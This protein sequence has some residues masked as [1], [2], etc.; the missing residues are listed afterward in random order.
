[1]REH[2]IGCMTRAALAKGYRLFYIGEL[3]YQIPELLAAPWV[4]GASNDS[5]LVAALAESIGIAQSDIHTLPGGNYGRVSYT[6]SY[7]PEQ[8]VLNV[9]PRYVAFRIDMPSDTAAN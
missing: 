1:M 2:L 6:L 3:G 7:P 8:F 4:K 9:M 5:Q